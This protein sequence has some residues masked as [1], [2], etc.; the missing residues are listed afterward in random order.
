MNFDHARFLIIRLSSIGDVL[1]ATAVARSLKRSCPTAHLTW[2]VSPPASELLRC[3]PDIDELLIWD[4]APFDRAIAGR[5]FLS[6]KRALGKARQ[7]LA[8]HHFDIALDIQDLFLTGLLARM[9]GAPRR[10]GIHERHEFNQLFM[11][12]HAPDIADPHKVR[13][14]LSVL[15]PLGIPADE[16]RR[17]LELPPALDTF[18]ARFWP[19]H[20][21][22]PAQP[23]LLVN[24]RTTWPDKNWQPEHFAAALQDLPAA[25]QIVFCGS[26][27]DS[28]Y[29]EAAR[30]A[31][32]RPT[33]SIAGE[34]DLLELAAL[35]RSATLLLTCDTGPLHIATALGAPTLSLWGPTHPKIYGPLNGP[36][37]FVLSPHDCTACCKTHCRFHTNACM[38]AIDPA[39][40]ARELQALLTK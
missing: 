2:L 10:I 26:T 17:V 21:I 27:G 12:E 36:H 16:S 39:S 3:N 30:Q 15:A 25:V 29:I 19:A 31:L 35:I 34:T 9:S 18:A 38:E 6:A 32:P 20:G 37:R 40:V 13:R 14:Y 22:D 1:H 7:L 11:T 28:T 5:H 33:Y 23:L 4:R 8:G 24:T